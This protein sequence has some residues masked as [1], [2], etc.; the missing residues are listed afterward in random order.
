MSQ[1]TLELLLPNQVRRDNILEH[2]GMAVFSG[3][4]RDSYD[5][6]I[7]GQAFHESASLEHFLTESIEVALPAAL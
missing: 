5:Y 1:I 2:L 6:V 4:E 3:L 7:C